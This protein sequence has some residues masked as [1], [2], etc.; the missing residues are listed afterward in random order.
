M[1]DSLGAHARFGGVAQVHETPCRKRRAATAALMIS[2]RR[3]CLSAGEMAR[4]RT[5]PTRKK[6]ISE[7]GCRG[8]ARRISLWQH[9]RY[10]RPFAGSGADHQAPARRFDAVAHA[11]EPV[12]GRTDFG[13]VESLAVVAD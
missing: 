12:R 7:K 5:G 1:W 11:G 6:E 10:A 8:S 13:D 9:G 3:E 4:C 2:G